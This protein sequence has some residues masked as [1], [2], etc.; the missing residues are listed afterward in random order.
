M[1]LRVAPSSSFKIP[2]SSPSAFTTCVEIQGST[3]L[4]G[5]SLLTPIVE[6]VLSKINMYIF[7]YI[8]DN[9]Q[10]KC[11][12]F[13]SGVN[14]YIFAHFFMFLSP[15]LLTLGEI[16]GVKV[17]G[18]NFGGANFLTNSMSAFGYRQFWCCSSLEFFDG[19]KNHLKLIFCLFTINF[20]SWMVF[21]QPGASS[22]S[23]PILRPSLV[24]RATKQI[25][26]FQRM[27]KRF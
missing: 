15:K 3:N 12:I 18:W 4:K 10:S 2:R 24:P 26:K 25:F 14:F 1:R 8:H 17:L 22:S 11:K 16:D 19:S 7:W 27:S 9:T 5:S 21:I 13:A 23:C 6:T 20:D